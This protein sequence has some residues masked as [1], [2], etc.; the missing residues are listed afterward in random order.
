VHYQNFRG[1]DV[2]EALSRVRAVLGPDA[3]IGSTRHVRSTGTFAPGHVVIEAA[4]GPARATAPQDPPRLASR[5]SGATQTPARAAA[6]VRAPTP[7]SGESTSELGREVAALRAAVRALEA[8]C[9]PRTHALGRLQMAGIEGQLASELAANAPRTRKK[10]QTAATWLRRRVGERLR[11][12]PGLIARPGRQL[13]ACVGPTGA[14]KTTTLAKLAVKAQ[15]DLGRSVGVVS[16]DGFRVG[17]VEQ[18][19]RY[20]KLIGMP[21][22]A[23]RDAAGLSHALRAIDSEIVL[24]DTEGQVPNGESLTQNLAASLEVGGNFEAHTLLVVPAW[25][26]GSDVDRMVRTYRAPRP[27]AVVVTKLDE[28]SNVGGVLHACLPTD[29]PLAYLCAG[30]RVPE[31]LQD[32]RIET[33][34]DRLFTDE[35]AS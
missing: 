10:G 6:P 11:V 23:A 13:I 20:A 17:A 26:R 24:V 29:T 18:W 15:L 31:D 27:T 7:T 35:V 21:F 19:Q 5:P 14:G 33:V 4:R 2:N 1:A 12:A 8:A 30:P 16:L 32:A 34:L 28:A 3:V 9:S 25:L 22:F